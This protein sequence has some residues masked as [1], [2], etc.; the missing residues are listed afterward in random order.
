M[1]LQEFV[2]STPG[3]VILVAVI[4]VFFL[5]IL[6]TGKGKKIDTKALVISALLIA[7]AMVLDQIKLFTMPQGGSVHPFA[8]LPIVLCGYFFGVRRGVMAGF[9]MGLLQLLFSPYVI[10]PVQMLLDY[11]V[12]FGALALGAVFR[13][14]KRGALIK[15]YIFGVFCRYIVAVI[16]GVVFFGAYIPDPRFNALT[17]SLWYNFTYIAIEAAVTIAILFIPAVA[18]MFKTLRSQVSTA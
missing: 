3:Q 13:N 4:V 14:N 16:S 18:N 1:T 15:T 17:W 11:P 9:C 8:M 6:L 10:H 12:A 2:E 5:I 7:L